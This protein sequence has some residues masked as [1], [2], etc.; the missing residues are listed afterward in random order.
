MARLMQN[1]EACHTN[2][3][4]DENSAFNSVLYYKLFCN[5]SSL[6]QQTISVKQS[7]PQNLIPRPLNTKVNNISQFSSVPQLI[8][9]LQEF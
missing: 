3:S 5:G 1:P 7:L 9:K 2:F 6:M 4:F 8:I